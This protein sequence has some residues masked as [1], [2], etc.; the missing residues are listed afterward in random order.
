MQATL[1][2]AR[3]PDVR[4]QLASLRRLNE[5]V[6][7]QRLVDEVQQDYHDLFIDTTWPACPKHPNHPLWYHDGTWWCP[8]DEEAIAPLG[9]LDALR[10]TDRA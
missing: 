3:V 9:G 8:R 10:A 6:D 2:A 7:A 5:H 4:A 1:G